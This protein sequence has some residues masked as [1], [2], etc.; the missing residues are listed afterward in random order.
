MQTIPGYDYYRIESEL[1][2]AASPDLRAW[3][4]ADWIESRKHVSPT[5]G[6]RRVQNAIGDAYENW[7]KPVVLNALRWTKESERDLKAGRLA[8]AMI[9]GER[10]YLLL[11]SQASGGR[12]THTHEQWDASI[13]ARYGASKALVKA[14]DEAAI[15]VALS[16]LPRIPPSVPNG[17][18]FETFHDLSEALHKWAPHLTD[19][20]A[21]LRQ[22]GNV[23]ELPFSAKVG[24]DKVN[25][26]VI[27][28]ACYVRLV[29]NK[30]KIRDN[31]SI[32]FL[33]LYTSS[34]LVAGRLQATS[35]IHVA[36]PTSPTLSKVKLVAIQPN[37]YSGMLREEEIGTFYTGWPIS[38]NIQSVT[39]VVK[40]L[41]DG[42]WR[43][44]NMLVHA[45]RDAGY[46]E[47]SDSGRGKIPSRAFRMHRDFLSTVYTPG[48]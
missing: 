11:S 31:V 1:R 45:L 8:D 36:T 48:E 42:P 13:D 47:I 18:R 40:A 29:I 19:I 28:I 25:S 34:Q 37:R 38:Y 43:T 5:A 24:H 14:G 17:S 30:G 32:G 16:E 35:W 3:M 6:T 26:E 39:S 7:A 9:K 44:H 27:Q 15:V 23:V 20:L 4:E 21:P 33:P 41:K 22:G 10:A 12:R 2:D 46:K